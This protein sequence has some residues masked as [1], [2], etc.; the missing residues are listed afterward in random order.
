M[1][2]K[3]LKNIL[4][5]TERGIN[6]TAL[7]TRV[8]LRWPVLLIAALVFSCFGVG[9]QYMAAGKAT[10][11]EIDPSVKTAD[12]AYLSDRIDEELAVK[13]NYMQNSVLM[14]LDNKAVPTAVE[15]IYVKNSEEPEMELEFETG[16]NTV[17]GGFG[18]RDTAAVI[19]I[20][21]TYVQYGIDLK[22]LAAELQTE[23]VYLR[24]LIS[25]SGKDGIATVTAVYKDEAGAEK[26][27]DAVVAD[28]QANMPSKLESFENIELLY[29]GK[30]VTTVADNT[31]N[32]QTNDQAVQVNNLLSNKNT[33]ANYKSIFALSPEQGAPGIKS[34][35]KTGIKYGIV[36]FVLALIA[37][38]LKL[39]FSNSVLSADEMNDHY[40]LN[41]LV[42]VPQT[43]LGGRKLNGLSKKII[44][45]DPDSR[46]IVTPAEI[47]NQLEE[48]INT[49]CTGRDRIAVISDLSDKE[50]S[51]FIGQFGETNGKILALNHLAEKPEERAQLNQCD[52]AILLT[53][54][55]KS[56]YSRINEILKLAIAGNIDIIGTV[57]L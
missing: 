7:I 47:T 14:N 50:V 54:V 57:T 30:E 53:R 4:D 32:T 39:V 36:G 3:K 35:L 45:L 17:K 2:N 55:E 44:R 6:L 37:V 52:K 5:K 28:L 56:K 15:M 19:E 22:G 12:Y 33:L 42:S 51:A 49:K 46:K 38:I 23:E 48:A 41:K 8:L 40:Q 27:L 24:E 43:T 26:I 18:D 31:K 29:I 21:K 25:V 16:N 11:E 20:M 10:G 1:Q 9:R 34:Y 13:R